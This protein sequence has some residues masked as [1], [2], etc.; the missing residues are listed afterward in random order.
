[1]DY[2]NRV[3]RRIASGQPALGGWCMTGSTVAAEV[4]ARSGFDWVCIDAEHSSVDMTDVQQMIMAIENQGC[5]PFVR[6]AANQESDIKRVLDAGA[7]GIIVPM[8]K[9]AADAERAVRYVKYPPIGGRSYALSRATDYGANSERYFKAANDIVFLTIMIEHI[10]AL[11]DLDRILEIKSI[12]A[13]LVGPYDLSGSMGIPGQFDNSDFL[14]AMSEITRKVKAHALTMGI[15][16]VHPT[17][18]KVRSYIDQ[19]YRFIALGLDTLFLSDSS[20]RILQEC[21][22]IGAEAEPPIAVVGGRIAR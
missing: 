12:D 15:H 16:E 13:V 9:S 8:V 1:M 14:S 7:K 21:G 6:I 5:E 2:D 4:L 10:D 17:P 3:M 22:G 19:G 11:R 18:A 20:T